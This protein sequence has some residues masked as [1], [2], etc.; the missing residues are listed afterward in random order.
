MPTFVFS[1]HAKR[2][3]RKLDAQTQNRI[4]KKIG[5]LRADDDYRSMTTI[6]D[7]PPATH[8]LRVGDYRLVLTQKESSHFLV[9]DVD[10]RS[11]IYR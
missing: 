1:K 10:H 9:I 7:A 2:K 8:R 4:L 5:E 6:K 11:K 3:F